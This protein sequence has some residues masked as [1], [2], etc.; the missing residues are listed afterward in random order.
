MRF[1]VPQ[2][3]V[4][5]D[6]EPAVA[7]AF[8]RALSRLSQAGASIVDVPFTQLA[9]IATLGARGTFAVV[10]GY[11]WHRQ[12]LDRDADRYDPIVARRFAGGA[13]VR[14]ADYIALVNGRRDLIGRAAPVTAPFDAMLMPTLPIVAP[15]IADYAGNEERWLA[16][17]R[18]MTRNPGVANFLDRCAITLPC[19]DEGGPQVGI[20]V[21]GETLGDRRL[22][23]LAHAME[24]VLRGHSGSDT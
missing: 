18:L 23:A 6:L 4:L 2:T 11:A 16:T 17:N 22:L 7:R 19:H 14:S 10:E 21:M 24:P 15:P 12:R 3:L 5:D 20:S 1:G 9:E 13:D 8:A